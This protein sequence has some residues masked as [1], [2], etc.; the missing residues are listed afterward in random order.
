MMR[1]LRFFRPEIEVALK[2]AFVV[3]LAS[4]Y[5]GTFA[6]GYEERQR[7]RQ[8]RQIACGL[9]LTELERVTPGFPIRG[10]GPCETL[11]RL[12]VRVVVERPVNGRPSGREVTPAVVSGS[13]ELRTDLVR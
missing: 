3:A 4:A 10:D 2:L 12:G 6:W 5:L 11:D 8:W 7:A 1:I 9:R 13:P